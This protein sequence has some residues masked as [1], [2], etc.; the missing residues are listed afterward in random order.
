[1]SCSLEWARIREARAPVRDRLSSLLARLYAANLPEWRQLLSTDAPLVDSV[2]LASAAPPDDGLPISSLS[3]PED[4]ARLV[5]GRLGHIVVNPQDL[6]KTTALCDSYVHAEGQRSAPDV[7]NSSPTRVDSFVRDLVARAQDAREIL[8][9]RRADGTGH[10]LAAINGL[11][12]YGERGSGKTFLLNHMLSRYSDYLDSQQTI[13]VR[14]NL[15][16]AFGDDLNLEHWALAQAT[17]VILRYYDPESDFVDRRKRPQVPALAHLRQFVQTAASRATVTRLDTAV[18]RLH[19]KFQTRGS[20]ASVD[21]EL[22]PAILADEVV[23]LAR[24]CGYSLIVFFD[25]LDKLE[26]TEAA[27]RKFDLLA[28]GLDA[29]RASDTPRGIA[30]VAV[31]RSM[32]RRCLRAAHTSPYVTG[33]IPTWRIA[34]VPLQDIVAKRLQVI[35]EEL[36]RR[37]QREPGA[38]G[39]WIARIDEFAAYLKSAEE[40]LIAVEGVLAGNVRAQTQIIQLRWLEYLAKYD[41]ASY[42]IVEQLM[43]AGEVFPPQYYGYHVD[44][45]GALHAELTG[46][47]SFDS[48]FLPSLFS[49]P[50]ADNVAGR[51]GGMRTHTDILVGLRILQIVAAHTFNIRESGEG[52]DGLTGGEL[53]EICRV[54]FGYDER[55]VLAF[56]GELAEFEVLTFRGFLRTRPAI[57]SYGEIVLLPK[58]AYLLKSAIYDIAY[59]NLASMRVR[60]A[61]LSREKDVP[62]LAAQAKRRRTGDALD[63]WVAHKVLNSSGLLRLV[64]AVNTE[65]QT[66]ALAQTDQ[67]R[68]ERCQRAIKTAIEGG[69]ANGVG[70]FDVPARMESV[71]LTQARD[72]ILGAD[73]YKHDAK[74][75]EILNAIQ[76]YVEVW[77]D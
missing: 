12:L 3:S 51:G 71:L 64:S 48:K 63:R 8:Y 45:R 16:N 66:F 22:V 56:I 46:P 26:V 6:E 36:K 74:L 2:Q 32:T 42:R 41:P 33:R 37:Q 75:R 1:M 76:R 10:G 19:Q 67:I 21:P 62:F 57:P 43:Y 31:M 73:R 23:R 61:T 40:P 77:V 38:A 55:V 11:D 72:M 28:T 5:F 50:Y 53:S 9:T 49:P 60:L 27:A 58:G 68:D 54:M 18:M 24:D 52:A 15:V 13:W 59:L 39:T 4:I 20:D 14:V 70:M 35:K 69:G 25:G 30:H 47:T 17:K 65:Q 34:S 29:W 7:L 44:S